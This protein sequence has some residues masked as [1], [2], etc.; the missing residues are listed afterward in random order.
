MAILDTTQ[1]APAPSVTSL[2]STSYFT[3]AA[4][5]EDFVA[6]CTSMAHRVACLLR[7]ARAAIRASE[8]WDDADD[9]LHAVLEV[10][11]AAE[12]IADQLS[13]VLQGSVGQFGGVQS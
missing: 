10:L 5:Y 7:T 3:S 11:A 1:S 8:A 12:E 2:S 9:E 6:P 13:T 4:V